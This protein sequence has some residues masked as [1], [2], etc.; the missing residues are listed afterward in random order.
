MNTLKRFPESRRVVCPKPCEPRAPKWLKRRRKPGGV[1]YARM[2]SQHY[3]L[4]SGP[5]LLALLDKR[6]AGFCPLCEM[7]RMLNDP[8]TPPNV[9]KRLRQDLAAYGRVVGQDPKPRD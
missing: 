7:E 9:K 5:S 1:Y 8:K 3:H 2:P 6:W 4:K